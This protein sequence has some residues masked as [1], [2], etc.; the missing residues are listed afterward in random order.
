MSI[1]YECT[2]QGGFV[3]NAG[4]T[5]TFTIDFPSRSVISKIIVIQTDGT[6]ANFSVVLFNNAIAAGGTDQSESVGDY[7][8]DLPPDLYRVT[9]T[10]SATAGKLLYFS[11][12]SNGGHGFVFFNQDKDT[13]ANRL[14]NP[15]K[16]YLQITVP[17]SSGDATFAV[18]IAGEIFK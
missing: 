2:P 16:L 7:Q 6:P 9:P 4:A 10:L 5:E 17:G 18:T 13:M 3:V 8:G 15:H 14:G 12:T 11:E 1:P